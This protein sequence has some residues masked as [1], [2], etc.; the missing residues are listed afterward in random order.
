MEREHPVLYFNDR[1]EDMKPTIITTNYNA[2][3]LV[4]ALTPKGGAERKPG[5]L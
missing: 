4:R 1:Y 2:D 3:E 5:P